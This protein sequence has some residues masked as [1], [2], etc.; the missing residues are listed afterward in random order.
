MK[1]LMRSASLALLAIAVCTPNADAQ[2]SK[3]QRAIA[4]AN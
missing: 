2:V 1:T 4:K 3:C